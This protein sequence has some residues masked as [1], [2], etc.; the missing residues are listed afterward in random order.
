MVGRGMRVAE[1]VWVF[2]L[3]IK[4]HCWSLSLCLSSIHI[5]STTT[6]HFKLLGHYL[7]NVHM[8]YII[9]NWPEVVLFY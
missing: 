3:N 2:V 1:E 5:Y 9:F 8:Q 7:A 6:A 4:V